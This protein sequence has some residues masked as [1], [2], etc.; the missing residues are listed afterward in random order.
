MKAVIYARYSS[1][2]QR[3]ESIEGQLRECKEYAAKNDITIVGEYIDRAIS[4]KTDQRPS[5]QKMIAD[6]AKG[7]FEAVLMYTLDR[8]ARNRYDSAIYKAM[9]K[10]NGVRTIYA[11]QPMPDT[12]EGIILES[13]LEGYAEYYSQNLAR[14]IK[15][16]LKENALECRY[17]IPLLGYKKGEDGKY[18]ID[19]AGAKIVREIY[20][21][22]DEGWSQ[23]EI[24]NYCNERGYRTIRGGKFNKNSVRTLIQNEKYIGIYTWDDVRVEGGIPQIID[25]DLFDR[26]TQK[27]AHLRKVGAKKEANDDYLLSGKLF[28]GECGSPMVGESG[29]SHTGQKYYYYKCSNRK[30]GGNC[31]KHTEKKDEIER[32]VTA[33][34]KERVL[35]D[36]TIN[37]IADKVMEIV[38]KDFADTSV[39]ESLKSSLSD[40]EKKIKNILKAIEAGIITD[41]TKQR[42]D[43]LESERKDLEGQIAKEEVKK[44]FLNK[45]RIIFWLSSFKNGDIDDVHYQQIL[46]DTLVNSAYIYDNDDGGRKIVIMFNLSKQNTAV[47][48]GSD[49]ERSTPRKDRRA[50]MSFGLLLSFGE[51]KLPLQGQ[52]SLFLRHRSQSFLCHLCTVKSRR[53]PF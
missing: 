15:R 34:T 47:I 21:K 31:P 18:A 30:R 51:E 50:E 10:K 9:L 2:N 11:K 17:N 44:P 22:Y 27:I 40:V 41:S 25:K 36:E 48:K 4:G 42:L 3:E 33:I 16:G 20:Q 43:E 23:T 46:I 1:H 32:L 35:T 7:Q 38:N 12:P 8:F 26:V 39:L 24:I 37:T 19:E 6:S 45:D 52:G 28:C 13:V 29:T 5:F 49:I 53:L 14:S